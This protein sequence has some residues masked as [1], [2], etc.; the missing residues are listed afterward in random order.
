MSPVA[1]KTWGFVGFTPRM[2]AEAVHDV[3]ATVEWSVPW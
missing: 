2:T 1:V 3:F